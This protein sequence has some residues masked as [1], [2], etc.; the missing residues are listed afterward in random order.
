MKIQDKVLAVWKSLTLRE[1][2]L[3]RFQAKSSTNSLL[4]GHCKIILSLIAGNSAREIAKSKLC[5]P[6]QVYRVAERFVELGPRGLA[7]RRE[8]NDRAPRQARKT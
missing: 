2:R 6:S 7:D 1:R 3:I 5:S 4:R 8:D